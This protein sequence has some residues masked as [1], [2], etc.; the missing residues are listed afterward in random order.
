LLGDGIRGKIVR[1]EG[2]TNCP[3][4]QAASNGRSVS[5]PLVR[6][7]GHRSGAGY[8]LGVVHDLRRESPI[9]AWSPA[10]VSVTG[11]E[12][13]AGV[14]RSVTFRYQTIPVSTAL[15][16]GSPQT[17][18]LLF[19]VWTDGAGS[20]V[21]D[22]ASRLLRCNHWLILDRRFCVATRG[23]C[24]RWILARNRQWLCDGCGRHDGPTAATGSCYSDG[25]LH[26]ANRS[27]CR[28][29]FRWSR[30][31]FRHSG[32]FSCGLRVLDRD[33]LGFGELVR[34]LVLA[35]VGSGGQLLIL[36]YSFFGF[37]FRRFS[38]SVT[39]DLARRAEEHTPSIGSESYR[40]EGGRS[41]SR[42][43]P[44]RTCADR[45]SPCGQR[46]LHRVGGYRC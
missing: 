33:R 6:A 4:A 5:R 13:A 27:W 10:R 19:L 25:S 44:E 23:S 37:W 36:I 35:N 15:I 20:S 17:V 45:S 41:R 1:C 14:R 40:F 42:D 18:S 46:L 12:K 31:R 24:P 39:D 22:S 43:L 29:R 32:S 34:D 21:Q 16:F 11:S 7:F 30:N 9:R 2:T 26:I 38:D 3:P 8:R 28:D